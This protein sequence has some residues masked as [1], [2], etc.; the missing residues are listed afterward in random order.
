MTTASTVSVLSE[1]AYE[2]LSLVV[3]VPCTTREQWVTLLSLVVVNIRCNEIHP[4]PVTARLL[5]NHAMWDELVEHSR[6]IGSLW[7]PI[8]FF[9]VVIN[10]PAAAVNDR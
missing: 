5:P 1:H 4:V 3:L 7:S 9:G 10:A 6:M 8:A 2:P